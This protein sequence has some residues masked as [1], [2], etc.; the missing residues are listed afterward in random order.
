[1]KFSLTTLSGIARN[2][3]CV[4]MLS[5]VID[6]LLAIADRIEV[7]PTFTTIDA[8]LPFYIQQTAANKK[9]LVEL[10]IRLDLLTPILSKTATKDESL[11]TDVVEAVKRSLVPSTLCNIADLFW[12][13][14]G[15]D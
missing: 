15:I 7:K 13:G 14:T 4:A 6:P 9:G 12:Q 3:P 2:I 10:A 8:V 5:S 11:G 1:L